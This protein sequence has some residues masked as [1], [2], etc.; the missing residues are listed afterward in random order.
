VVVVV[1]DEEGELEELPDP[2]ED[3]EPVVTVIETAPDVAVF[4]ALSVD[5]HV[6]L[7]VPVVEGE[8]V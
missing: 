1:V 8:Y 4:V 2:L 7:F 3:S 6:T 5:L